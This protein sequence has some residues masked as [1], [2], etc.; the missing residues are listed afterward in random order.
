MAFSAISNIA[1]RG[2]SACVP[3][4][5]ESNENSPLL[6]DEEKRGMIPAIGIERKRVAP[7][8]ICTSDL[9]RA[10]AEKLLAELGWEKPEIRWLVFVSQTPDYVLPATAC[11][12]QE[13]LGLS[14]SCAAIDV[15]LGCSGWV[16]GLNV[17][18]SL[19]AGTRGKGLLLAGDLTTRTQYFRDKTSF[20]LFGDAGTATAL[21]FSENAPP[22]FFNLETDGSGADAII[23]PDGGYR[24]P[25]TPESFREF[26]TDSGATLTRRHAA[27]N[28]MDIFAFAQSRVPKNIRA[29]F[30]KYEI[31]PASPDI[32]AFHQANLA[33]NERIRKKLDLPPEK[34]PYSLRNFGN[35]SSAS[36]PLTLVSECRASLN[37][38]GATRKILAC[39]FGVGL[40]LGSAFFETNAISVPALLEL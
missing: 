18:A 30:E 20:P 36:I 11:L 4:H 29:L 5:E 8:G 27:L 6:S 21:E 38:G 24:N 33:L 35:T 28:G 23:I 37:G 15:S 1:V 14:R 3:A 13:R 25:C 10:A 22:M 9:C 31:A 40:S 17:L 34:V 19:L 32:F 7:D 2:I 39:G 16:Y 26:T 12:L